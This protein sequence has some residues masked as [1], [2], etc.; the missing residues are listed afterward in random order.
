MNQTRVATEYI[1]TREQKRYIAKQNMK[2]AGKRGFCK[3][4]YT[5]NVDPITQKPLGST[6]HPSYF[7]EHWRE[8]ISENMEAN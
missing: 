5:S 4:S 2:K 1:V 6:R 3:H 8:Y 7:A